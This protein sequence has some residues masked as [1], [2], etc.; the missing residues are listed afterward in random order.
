MSEG[1]RKQDVRAVVPGDV[2]QRLGVAVR[3]LGGDRVFCFSESFQKRH[4]N[5]YMSLQVTRSN[6]L[7]SRSKNNDYV[8]TYMAFITK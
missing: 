2:G 7:A 4:S 3:D 5:M 8:R 1:G 6:L